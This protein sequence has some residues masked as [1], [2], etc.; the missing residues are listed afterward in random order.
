MY[1]RKEERKPLS[2]FFFTPPKTYYLHLSSSSPPT[3]PFIPIP[4][5]IPHPLYPP[6]FLPNPHTHNHNPNPHNPHPSPSLP[7]S[8]SPP[9]PPPSKSSRQ[10]PTLFPPSPFHTAVRKSWFFAWSEA[11]QTDPLAQI[12]LFHVPPI[13]IPIY[14]LLPSARHSAT[15]SLTHFHTLRRVWRWRAFSRTTCCWKAAGGLVDAARTRLRETD[16]AVTGF[17]TSL[18]A[19][20]TPSRM[21]ATSQPRIAA[22]MR[23]GF[24]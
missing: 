11:R 5:P 24:F 19:E 10:A 14:L 16:D 8:L 6:S 17:G 18:M 13:Y 9:K 12:Y 15:H 1:Q 4:I 7:S 23:P 3:L 22:M 2:P 20:P 21:P